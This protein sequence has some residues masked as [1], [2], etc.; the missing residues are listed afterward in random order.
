MSETVNELKARVREL[1]SS[2][3]GYERLA[4]D[5]VQVGD[6]TTANENF[7]A[8]A[9]ARNQ[10]EAAELQLRT[11]SA[12]E[13]KIAK[14]QAK[15]QERYGAPSAGH[16]I[17]RRITDPEYQANYHAAVHLAEAEQRLTVFESTVLPKPTTEQLRDQ[18]HEKL[19]ATVEEMRAGLSPEATTIRKQLTVED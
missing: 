13:A 17:A 1:K 7:A 6:H 10:L 16:L 3:L 12:A 14:E 15:F 8:H 5:A 2:A 19:R 4:I 9:T 18:A 11:T